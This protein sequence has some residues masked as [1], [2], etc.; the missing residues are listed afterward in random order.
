MGGLGA[1]FAA[2]AVFVVIARG[3]HVWHRMMIDNP[4]PVDAAWVRE[5]VKALVRR[6]PDPEP[7]PGPDPGGYRLE[8]DDQVP[9]RTRVVWA[10]REQG[11]PPPAAPAP[12]A[13][14]SRLDRWVAQSL[15]AGAR[16]VEV[17]TEGTRLF[18]CSDT[19]IKRAIR[20]VRGARERAAGAVRA[21]A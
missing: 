16:P 10:K 12:P 5:W 18:R 17:I 8:P 21:D 11:D 7:D 9:P 19:T 4:S 20:R 14:P 15:D 1:I 13:R 6:D 3:V 2:W